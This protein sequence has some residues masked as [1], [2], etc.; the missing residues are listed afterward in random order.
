[1]EPVSW[2]SN[3]APPGNAAHAAFTGL[4][5]L[6]RLYLLERLS[7]EATGNGTGVSSPIVGF[8]VRDAFIRALTLCILAITQNQ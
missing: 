3:F 5:S 7:A 8:T 6:R 1:M 4:F 2:R